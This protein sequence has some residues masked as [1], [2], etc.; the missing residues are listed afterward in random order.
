MTKTMSPF[1][2]LLK[3]KTRFAWD[4]DLEDAFVKSKAW[5][6]GQISTG[7]EIFDLNR[8]TCLSTDWS[9]D[10]IGYSLSQKHCSCPEIIPTCCKTGWRITLVGSRFT[11]PAESRYSAVAGEALAV[12]DALDKTKHFTLG[13]PNP[14]TTS[15]SSTFWETKSWATSRRHNFSTLRKRSDSGFCTSRVPSTTC[16]TLYLGTPRQTGPPNLHKA[17]NGHHPSCLD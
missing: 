16:L 5:I 7:V 1:R 12:A 17:S 15:L 8:H 11:T 2:A 14:R 6:L 4:H 10:G 13:C 3:S 9:K